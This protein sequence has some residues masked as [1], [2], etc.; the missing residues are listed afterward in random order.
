MGALDI[1]PQQ[2]DGEFT[3]TPFFMDPDYQGDAAAIVNVDGS[4][5][6]GTDIKDVYK[7]KASTNGK[8]QFSFQQSFIGE[9][10][11][12]SIQALPNDVVRHSYV[13][14]VFNYGK[15]P[16]QVFI[17]P[18]MGV[19]A[20]KTKLTAKTLAVGTG[21]NSVSNRFRRLLAR[22]ILFDKFR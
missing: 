11:N 20:F 21:A 1:G 17:Y 18:S 2:K 10:V 4:N 22:F 9:Q 16:D 5:S 14:T 13:H 8:V 6:K 7:A 12:A 19:P 15:D 3:S